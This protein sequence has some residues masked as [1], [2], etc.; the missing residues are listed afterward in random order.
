MGNGR[1]SLSS[2]IPFP[3]SLVTFFFFVTVIGGVP[4]SLSAQDANSSNSSTSPVERERPFIKDPQK[5]EEFRKRM[6]E[7]K[8]KMAAKMAEKK[9]KKGRV[10]F[11]MA[12]E[13]GFKK[14]LIIGLVP[15]DQLDATMEKWGTYQKANEM[16]KRKLKQRVLDFRKRLRDEALENAK[17][18]GLQLTPE[19]QGG[20]IAAYWKKRMEVERA[21]RDRAEG[22]LK[23]AMEGLNEVLND[24]FAVSP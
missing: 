18:Q 8:K 16:K 19:Q 4:V 22:E 15:E 17:K 9:K 7:R 20:Y 24:E 6:E 2:S 14:R 1:Y 13:K 10:G 5:R 11:L 12:G 21:I 23:T 3:G